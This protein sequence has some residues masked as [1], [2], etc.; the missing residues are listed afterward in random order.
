[1][2]SGMKKLATTAL[3]IVFAGATSAE[4]GILQD[5]DVITYQMAIQAFGVSKQ[6]AF[7][8]AQMA[9]Q[10]ADRHSGQDDQ[11]KAGKEQRFVFSGNPYLID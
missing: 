9:T 2:K 5:P 3:P 1:M 11:D 7:A 8:A 6:A 4:E 10:E